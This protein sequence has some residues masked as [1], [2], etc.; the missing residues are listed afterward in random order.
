MLFELK[1]TK[2]H[3]L[4]GHVDSISWYD[5]QRNWGVCGLYDSQVQESKELCLGFKKVIREIRK[6]QTKAQ[7]CKM[8]IWN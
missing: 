6:V 8:F 1:N 3:I 7:P 2:G 4:E 5:A